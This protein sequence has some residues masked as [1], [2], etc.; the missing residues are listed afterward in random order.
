MK[1]EELED[2]VG[3]RVT[4]RLTATAPGTPAVT[5]RLLGVL[6][7]LDGT[8]VTLDPGGAHAPLT[9]HSHYIDRVERV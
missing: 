4:L 8:V 3:E 6:R 2:L 9:Y 1:T 5:G 7:A